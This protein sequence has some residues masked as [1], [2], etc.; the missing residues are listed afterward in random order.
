MGSGF[1]RMQRALRENNNPTLEISATNFFSIRFYKR[2]NSVMEHG[3]TSRQMTLY[4]AFQAEKVLSKN[5]AAI[6]INSS[7][8]T[9]LR[10]LQVLIERGLVEKQGQGRAV[11]YHYK[12]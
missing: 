1:D 4:R 7:G 12:A 10:E 6:S 8:D 11:S 5:Q 9:A 3:L 2:L